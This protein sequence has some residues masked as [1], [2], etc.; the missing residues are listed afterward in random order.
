MAKKLSDDKLKELSFKLD[1][2]KTIME[3]EVELFPNAIDN[4]KWTIR[5]I[6]EGGIFR[7]KVLQGN[8]NFISGFNQCYNDTIEMCRD[9]S[10]EDRKKLNGILKEKFG[11]DLNDADKKQANKVESILTR[12]KLRSDTEYYL[13]KEW[14]DHLLWNGVVEDE[15][16]ARRLDELLGEYEQRVVAK[17]E[18]ANKRKKEERA[19]DKF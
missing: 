18:K 6:K 17:M 2:V 4:F 19:D 13:A 3:F 14:V 5:N 8:R 16:K 15:E 7:E 10:P 12:G 1:W 11:Y 9:W